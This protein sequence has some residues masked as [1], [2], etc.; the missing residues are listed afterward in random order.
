MLLAFHDCPGP[1]MNTRPQSHFEGR[2]RGVSPLFGEALFVCIVVVLAGCLSYYIVLDRHHGGPTELP[3]KAGLERTV[4]G[5]WTLTIDRGRAD[6]DALLIIKRPPG[7]VELAVGISMTSWYFVFN[8]NNGDGY[9]DAGDIILL[10][11]TA[12]VV[13]AGWTVELMSPGI[14]SLTG[15]LTLPD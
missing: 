3:L 14:S 12:G 10:N 13:E 8:D 7:R 1:Q 6:K 11:Q 2:D 5:N 4:K 15:P 9:I